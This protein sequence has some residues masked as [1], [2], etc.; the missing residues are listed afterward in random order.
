M[1]EKELDCSKEWN[2]FVTTMLLHYNVVVTTKNSHTTNFCLIICM[3]QGDLFV[4]S[5]NIQKSEK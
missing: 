3:I 4:V 5:K 1:K 2:K